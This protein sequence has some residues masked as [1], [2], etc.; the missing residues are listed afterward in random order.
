MTP[1]PFS[2]AAFNRPAS[3]TTF[4]EGTEVYNGVY[5]N[6]IVDALAAVSPGAF[7]IGN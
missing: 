5:G 2:Y 1:N 4:C 6:G 3:F 7:D